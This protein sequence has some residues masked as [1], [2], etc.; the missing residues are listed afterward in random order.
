MFETPLDGRTCY[1]QPDETIIEI[2]L[3]FRTHDNLVPEKV[4]VGRFLIREI[5]YLCLKFQQHSWNQ[6][7]RH[8]GIKSDLLH[9]NLKHTE[10]TS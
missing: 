5:G 1:P 10:K 8:L 2:L 4:L 7:V 6:Q 3:Y 9:L